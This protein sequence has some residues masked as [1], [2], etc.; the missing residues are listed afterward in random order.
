MYVAE[1][2]L[3]ALQ[4]SVVKARTDLKSKLTRKGISFNTNDT[5]R[6]LISLIPRRILVPI[7]LYTELSG[8]TAVNLNDSEIIFCGGVNG[9]HSYIQKS[10][11]TNTNTFT[12]KKNY[13][14]LIINHAG[15]KW[16]NVVYYCGGNVYDANKA[17]D[18]MYAYNVDNNTFTTKT[19]VPTTIS[20]HTFVST[21][22]YLLISGG[23]RHASE[24]LNGQYTYDVRSNSYSRQ[25]NLKQ[26]SDRL[27][28]AH[29]ENEIVLINGGNDITNNKLNYT[30]NIGDGVI[31]TKR[32][33]PIARAEHATL[34]I[35]NKNVLIVGGFNVTKENTTQLFN[36]NTNTFTNK[37]TAPT[38][39]SE[40]TLSK[41]GEDFLISGPTNKQYTYH[42]DDDTYVIST[43]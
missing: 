43:S 3:L 9:N 31:T 42:Y 23:N 1:E 26:P 30:F 24:D 28:T 39:W 10:Y 13:P 17:T 38:V 7:N 41:A 32:D 21:N 12:S 16:G 35:Y 20:Y 36:T 34:K 2:R 22:R 25:N 11:N 15:A 8:H 6:K 27:A 33:L 19:N 29:I 40:H 14:A 5:L 18:S 4:N 37:R